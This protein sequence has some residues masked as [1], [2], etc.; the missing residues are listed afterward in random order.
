MA[1]EMKSKATEETDVTTGDEGCSTNDI[2]ERKKKSVIWSFQLFIRKINQSGMF[3]LQR[4]S[5]TRWD[6]S[7]EF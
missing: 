7:E 6:Q 4:E 3:E 1:A 2:V 5:V